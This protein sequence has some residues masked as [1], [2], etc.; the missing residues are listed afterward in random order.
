MK[1][2]L[3]LITFISLLLVLFIPGFSLAETKT[4]IKEYAY[5]ASDEDSKN[6]CRIIALREVKRL[7]LEE[8]GTYLES[9][10][11]VKNFQ[12]SRDQITTLT[13]GIVQTELVDEKWD[14]ANLKYW[15]KAKIKADSEGVLKAIDS[16]RKDRENIQELAE[17]KKSSE[18]L[19][20]ENKRLREE[21]LTA[22]GAN[23]EKVAEAYNKTVKELSAVE[24]HEKGKAAD[25]AG[26][27]N[28]AIKDY[29]RA[30][31]LNPEYTRAYGDRGF[32][33]G[34]LGNYNQAIENY[35]KAIELN[36]KAVRA[37][38][39]RGITYGK[40]GNRNQAK[41]DLK[42]AARLGHKLAQ[43]VLTNQG[44]AW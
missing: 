20:K 10:T 4:F 41:A 29:D 23:K 7:L 36:P 26:D 5:Q 31:E 22:R 27:H 44:I 32:A 35:S 28:Q 34:Q 6:S 40:L 37:Y 42:I 38:Y 33:Y 19:L 12:L 15:I 8:L 39:I 11:E 43:K 30:I 3:R 9:E 25:I 2:T 1:T 21:L 17:V 14:T 13:A 18:D 16:L 24:W